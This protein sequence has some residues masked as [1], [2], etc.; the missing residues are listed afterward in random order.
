MTL[1]PRQKEIATLVAQGLSYRRVARSTG[2][3]V[4]TVTQ[5]VIDAA[6]RIPGPG[7]PRHKVTVWVARIEDDNQSDAA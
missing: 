6:A 2:L 3:T 4:R 1:T 7:T 5:H